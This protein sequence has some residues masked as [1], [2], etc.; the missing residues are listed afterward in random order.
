[1][2]EKSGDIALPYGGLILRGENFEVFA[3]FLHPRK[4]NHKNSNTFHLIETSE[5]RWCFCKLKEKLLKPDGPLSQSIP[6]SLILA[7]NEE[8]SKMGCVHQKS[9]Y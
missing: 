4:L 5:L 3:D 9:L 6:S 2:C 1:L 7:A 8:V